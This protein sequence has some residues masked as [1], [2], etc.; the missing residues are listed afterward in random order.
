MNSVYALQVVAAGPG[1]M[2]MHYHSFDKEKQRF[3][4]GW[5]SSP[6]GFKYGFPLM[7]LPYSCPSTL[8]PSPRHAPLDIP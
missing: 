7:I 1:D 3:V 6:D 8:L 5:A 4:V 2:R